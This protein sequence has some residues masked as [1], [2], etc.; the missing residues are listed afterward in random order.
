VAFT[1]AEVQTIIDACATAARQTHAAIRLPSRAPCAMCISVCDIEGVLLGVF[2]MEDTTLFSLEIS[3]T[4][5][6][7]SVYYSNP[8]SRDFDGPR[9]GQHPL[10]GIVPAGTAITC[11]T[12]GFLSQPKFPPTIDG[13]SLVGPLYSSA[14]E[15]RVATRFDQMG[16]APVSP[17]Q[18]PSVVPGTQSGIIFFPGSAPLYRNGVLIGGIG[19]SG[20]GVEQDDLVTY[21]GL[22][23]AGIALGFQLG[24]PSNLRCDRY[25]FAGVALPYFKFPQ[26]PDG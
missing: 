15:N 8:A 12:L 4:K 9:A 10:A 24:P 26:N 3:Y 17:A 11:R 16:F 19:V 18:D 22:S 1:A 2:R 5:A 23:A 25:E 6:R 20:D 13:S 7:N 14:L 21:R